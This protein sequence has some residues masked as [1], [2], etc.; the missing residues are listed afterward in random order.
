MAARGGFWLCSQRDDWKR[1]IS[2]A[3]ESEKDEAVDRQKYAEAL[4]DYNRGEPEAED[5][6]RLAGPNGAG[7]TTLMNLLLRFADPTTTTSR[8][9]ATAPGAGAC[10]GRATAPRRTSPS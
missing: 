10:A 9:S 6:I 5:Q 1:A 3:D 2:F 7:K 4:D 8:S